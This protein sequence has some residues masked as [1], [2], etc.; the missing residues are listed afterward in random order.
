MSRRIKGIIDFV[1]ETLKNPKYD[2]E[3]FDPRFYPAGTVRVKDAPEYRPNVIDTGTMI[4]QERIALQDL[5]GRPYLTT[6][7]DRTA[8]G[9]ILEGIGNQPIAHPIRLTGGQDYMRDD[10]GELWASG[11]G[12]VPNMVKAASEIKDQYGS[13]PVFMPWRMS[14][15]GG[16]FAHMTGQTMLSWA[17]ANMPKGVKKQLDS[18]MKL[19]VP[20]WAGVDDPKSLAQYGSLPDKQRK[21]A[22]NMMDKNFRNQGG[23]SQ[24]Q[25]RLAVSDQSQL[26]SP[27]SGFQNVGE[28]DLQ[29]GV[30][31]G[32]GNPT[33]PS[34]LAGEYSGTLDTD[35]TA[36]DLNPQRFARA[37]KKD[38]S[39]DSGPQGPDYLSTKD[40]PRRAMEVGY[41]G[42]L[43]DEP[44][45]RRLSDE[46]FKINSG[47]LPGIATA[48]VAGASLLGSEEADAGP[49]GL[50]R[51]VFPAPQRMFDPDDKAYKPFLESFG[52]TPGGRYLEMGP[53]GPKD[54]TGEYPESAQLG[55]GPDGKPKF[56]VAPTQATNIP[57]AK[58]PGRKIKTNLAKKKTGW[59]WT[60]A[61][62]GYDPDPDGGFPIVS[63][64]DGKDHY[65]TLNTDFPEGV[66]LARYPNEASEP[67]LKPTRKGY[68]NLGEKVGE[69]EMRGK[70]HPVY[71][72]I[73]IRQ[74][75][76]V[77][78]AGLLGAGMSEDA[79][80]SIVGV[81]SKLGASRADLKG[82]AT[83]MEAE[84]LSPK[85]IIEKT[86]WY[87][88]AQDGKWRTE[89]P[90]TN[91]KINLPD[92]DFAK[93]DK[94]KIVKRLDEI[95]DDPE[96]LSQYD[97]D[98]QDVDSGFNLGEADFAD[99]ESRY[100]FRSVG[101]LGK[102][103]VVFD[104]QLPPGEGYFDGSTITVSALSSPQEQRAAI[105]HELQHVIQ[106][107]ENFAEGANAKL[108]ENDKF[109]SD[110]WTESAEKKLEKL[111]EAYLEKDEYGFS[112][113]SGEDREKRDLLRL[114]KMK[115]DRFREESAKAGTENPF[116]MYLASTGEVE[117]RNVE[118][119]DRAMSP[120][121]L[122]KVA[123]F[124]TESVP[125]SN[126]IFR[127]EDD[128]VAS[129]EDVVDTRYNFYRKPDV[130]ASER[131]RFEGLMREEDRLREMRSSSFGKV[132]PELAA[133]RRSQIL[134]SIAEMGM[135]AFD[136]A[137]DTI[138]F[139]SQIPS[140]R[141]TG[142]MSERTPLRDS[143]GGL[144]DYNFMDE[145][146]RKAIEEAR[147]IGS[148]LGPI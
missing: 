38:G 33:Y 54:I 73:T 101:E 145:R 133:Y 136:S 100:G 43:I 48:G 45:L 121:G 109:Y 135:G 46:G 127:P 61:P 114:A 95:V 2:R 15:S 55:V 96:L 80:A 123:P 128:P 140:S 31:E 20:D 59:K 144:L 51:N 79:D 130:R 27:V 16:D 90:N 67:R 106:K 5:E 11:V 30:L 26:L 17:S 69:I 4:P 42:G 35:V 147:L 18:E 32:G 12:V 49:A 117:A 1:A 19:F 74:A 9:G 141:Y 29:R 8:A 22:M 40:A 6:M 75:A 63:V 81:F 93:T 99:A 21:Q 71:D 102:T 44:L 139:L 24:T 47:I 77:A 83:K 108:F 60:Q 110:R 56:Q 85:E 115:A 7:S 10:T 122:R 137:V 78:M 104:S 146:D 86:G 111:D 105:L 142:R 36:M 107:R 41:Y 129:F 37:R 53:D 92:V 88:G 23:I 132:S 25:A 13:S 103:R 70:K 94:T 148:L 119:R 65:Y 97:V 120:D 66:E 76:P 14:P 58:G 3:E 28:I 39:F 118:L 62:E 57:D 134:P 34:G 113:L 98:V 91:T 64:N 116:N 82:M 112:T 87:K 84:G 50:L 89:L 125:S 72:N 131:S 124:E 126:Q 138:D 143:L 68:V 52:Q